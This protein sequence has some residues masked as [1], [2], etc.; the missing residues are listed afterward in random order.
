MPR[1]YGLSE[2]I[3][4]REILLASQTSDEEKKPKHKRFGEPGAEPKWP[5]DRVV[6]M[7]HFRLEAA[8]DHPKKT[9]AGEVTFTMRPFN[10]GLTRVTLDAIDLNI[11]AVTLDS[12]PIE[13]ELGDKTITAIFPKPKKANAPF[14][15]AIKFNVQPKW[16]L[17]FVGPDKHY[18]K[19]DAQI[20]SQGQD[21]DN[22]YW[23]PCYDFP[24]QRATTELLAT[25]DER[26]TVIGN[27]RLVSVAHNKKKKTKTYHWH[28]NVPHVTYLFSIVAGEMSEHTDEWEGIPISYYVPVGREDEGKRSFGNTPK[29]VAFFSEITGVKYPYEK[30]AQS[31][32]IDFT[33]GGME[34]ISAVTQTERTLHPANV[35]PIMS[36]D[37]LVAH[38]LAHMWYGDLLTCRTW[39][40]GWLNEGFGTYF[41]GL[42][43][44]H[45]LGYDEFQLHCRDYARGYMDEDTNR[46]RRA[47]V[48]NNYDFPGE[49]F[50]GHLYPKAALVLHM[51]R[52]WLGDELFFKG[53]RNYT[54]KF[55]NGLV[56]TEDLRE[57]FEEV[58][59]YNLDWYFDQW[60]YHG[61]HPE[62]KVSHSYD[63]ATGVDKLTVEQTQETDDL[64]PTFRFFLNVEYVM[65]KGKQAVK[66]EVKE[67]K[68]EFYVK[69]PTKP[70][71]VRIDPGYGVLKTIDYDPGM[72]EITAQVTEDTDVLLRIHCVELLG[73]KLLDDKAIALLRK[74][75]TDDAFYGV[76]VEAATA[77]GKTRGEASIDALAAGLKDR[78]ARVRRSVLAALGSYPDSDRVLTLIRSQRKDKNDYLRAAAIGALAHTRRDEVK[79]EIEK[80][81]GE[82]SYH[83]MV[84]T[85]ALYAMADLRDRRLVP[86]AM[87]LVKPGNDF[88][89]RSAAMLALAKIGEEKKEERK[90]L[91]TLLPYI[92]D[93]AWGIRNAAMGS[94]GELG[95]PR[96]MSVLARMAEGDRAGANRRSVRWT[97][98]TGNRARTRCRAR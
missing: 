68:H 48:A 91:D 50:D 83:E 26:F 27:G 98:S 15:L 69:L 84:T 19:K 77:L 2:Y 59:G 52:R 43:M 87:K 96:A 49:I 11:E 29:M 66:F 78:D 54:R 23:F 30:F 57:A 25:V 5:R 64:T 80:A 75:L 82:P 73:K 60:I 85:T 76:R 95:D 42:W 31:T 94:L 16:G 65:K 63:A 55:S 21:E 36:S 40:H 9:V 51:M 97:A 46:Y 71:Y 6:D 58:T 70:K 22:R 93:P 38:E 32:A 37:G 41:E 81:V 3:N 44:E 35:Q 10:D 61:G 88:S 62:L 8:F 90:I 39:S 86:I 1:P 79:D 24:N 17:F 33:M 4:W 45:D 7:S 74:V 28:E 92:E 20:W 56:M 18:P 53:I 67:K 47:I 72:G 13:W 14:H 89:I 12:A 34:N